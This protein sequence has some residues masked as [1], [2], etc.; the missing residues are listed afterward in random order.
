MNRLKLFM[1]LLG[2]KPPG[3]HIEQHD[4]FFGIGT[5]LAELVPDIQ[6]SWPEAPKIHIDAWREVTEA[7]GY[8]VIINPRADCN[9]AVEG[10]KL[11]FLNLGG[12]KKG[13]F[14]EYHYRMLIV[15]K[16]K[17][18]AISKARKTSFYKHTRFSGADS[19]IDDKYGVDVDDIFQIEEILPAEIK[20]KFHIDLIPGS[21]GQVDTFH[22]G[23]IKLNN[24]PVQY[25]KTGLLP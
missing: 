17:S 14:E 8:Q 16:E 6:A 5:G 25:Q 1:V 21:G 18:A 9:D 4:I 23:Y 10:P 15:G 20:K 13:E 19:H 7:E 11:F 24:L 12:Y 3:R 22:L 2:C